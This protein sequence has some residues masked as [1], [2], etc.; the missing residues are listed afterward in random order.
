[1]NKFD[2]GPSNFHNSTNRPG[3]G[4][5]DKQRHN[6]VYQQWHQSFG[7]QQQG[8]AYGGDDN[9]PGKHGLTSKS[10]KFTNASAGIFIKLQM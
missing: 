6:P 9:Y 7:H 3:L 4:A 5:S 2:R 1:M 10:N 8:D